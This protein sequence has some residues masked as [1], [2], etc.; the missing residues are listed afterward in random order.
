MTD[1]LKHFIHLRFS[2]WE[3]QTRIVAKSSSKLF[4]PKKQSDKKV[5][6]IDKR[7]GTL[8]I[9]YYF[10]I[11]KR[12]YVSFRL[13]EKCSNVLFLWI[14]WVKKIN[15][16]VDAK[17]CDIVVTRSPDS[18]DDSLFRFLLCARPGPK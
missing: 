9:T 5:L 12:Q 11:R 2:S 14:W 7:E 15:K 8:S 13:I 4:T 16:T 3:R 17:P 1:K 10:D 18:G 6:K